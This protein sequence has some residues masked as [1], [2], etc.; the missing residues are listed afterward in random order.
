VHL[1]TLS[2]MLPSGRRAFGD[3][4]PPARSAL[5]G[6]RPRD[7]KLRRVATRLTA[8]K[9]TTPCVSCV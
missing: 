8:T 2:T 9:A 7:R 4:L 6:R 1:H 5:Q 3:P